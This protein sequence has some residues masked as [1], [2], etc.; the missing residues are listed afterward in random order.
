MDVIGLGIVGASG[1]LG[2]SVERLLAAR[3][4]GEFEVRARINREDE[5]AALADCDAIIDASLPAGTRRIVDWLTG[6][7]GGPGILVCGTTGI[8]AATKT[9]LVALGERMQ[10]LHASNFS[11]GVA[12]LRMLLETI[13]PMLSELGYSPVITETHHRRKK[14]A[15]S[16]TAL[17]LAESMQ[18]WSSDEIGIHSLRVGD[19]VG[20]HQVEFF[21]RDDRLVFGHEAVSRDAF[22]AGAIDAVA[23]MHSRRGASGW[24]TMAEYFA[25]RFAP[26]QRADRPR[27]E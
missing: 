12:A 7:S 18:G 26:R 3:H 2:R 5:P 21:G 27:S 22:A 23:W 24:F 9:R 6:R 17:T 1:R 15:P 25:E 13:S 11:P 16:G 10:V 8:D 4:P 14:D 19:V 20:R